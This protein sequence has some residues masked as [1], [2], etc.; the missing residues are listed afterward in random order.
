MKANIHANTNLGKR[1]YIN[2]L[3]SKILD[4]L[5]SL[6]YL[7]LNMGDVE[8]SSAYN[9]G[10]YLEKLCVIFLIQLPFKNDIFLIF[11]YIIII[12]L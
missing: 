12:K 2:G 3:S 8:S 1:P 5:S 4:L 7:F 11:I 6:K 10:P 9:L